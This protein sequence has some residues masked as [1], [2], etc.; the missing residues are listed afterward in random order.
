MPEKKQT[1]Y[2]K[3]NA[4]H[5][6]TDNLA[7][8][9]RFAARQHGKQPLTVIK[10]FWKLSRGPGKLTIYDYFLHRLYD[11]TKHTPDT[12]ARFISDRLH[13]PITHK[14]CD[15]GWRAITED[16]W[17]SYNLLDRFGIRTPK[18]IA[19]VD[20]S[21]RLF[22]SDPKITSPDSLKAF[23]KE[24]DSYPI[25]AKPNLGIASAGAFVIT[26]IDET[27]VC[28]D[29]CEPLT[30]EAIFQEIIG[31][32]S[33]LLQ[34]FVENH[35]L[36]KAFSKYVA[37]IRT[38]NLVGQDSVRTPFTLMKIPSPTNIAD[39]YWRKGN[40]I[41]DINPEN[42]VIRHV[43]RGKGIQTEDLEAHPDTGERL[44]G[45]ALPDWDKLRRV[46]DT[47]ARLFAP[48]RYQSL[49]VALTSDG[50]VVVEIN[51]GGS[52]ELPQLAAGTGLLTDE[53]RDFFESCGWKFRSKRKTS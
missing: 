1:L 5:E 19:V 2:Q 49:D 48:V 3:Q 46:N 24:T 51:T 42:G 25:F 26:G 9:F 8:L 44:V 18:T 17:I 39:N 37:T 16:K 52:F 45:L 12:K 14:C 28:L 31:E 47:C 53:V 4:V 11:D 27:H 34:T 43:I 35:P 23:L 6:Y 10:E 33:Y 41:A 20:Q 7:N 21:P 13:W 36:I 15:M 32:H 22:A 38:V 40:L 30:F 50:P 29:Q